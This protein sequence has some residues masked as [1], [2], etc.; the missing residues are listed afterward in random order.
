MAST[1]QINA[2]RLSR[3]QQ[4]FA[5][6]E[7][8]EDKRAKS[9]LSEAFLLW[10]T[11]P[12]VFPRQSHGVKI[13]AP[14][15]FLLCMSSRRRNLSEIWMVLPTERAYLL[16]SG[17]RSHIHETLFLFDCNQKGFGFFSMHKGPYSQL[18]LASGKTKM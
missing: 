2:S 9:S 15:R 17:C 5:V 11:A 6:K 18:R 4:E 13:K 1:C 3:G 16:P 12:A 8:K 14:Y 7:K 10:A